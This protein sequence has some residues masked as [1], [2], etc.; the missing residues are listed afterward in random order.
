[1]PG[2]VLVREE[3]CAHSH[4]SQ[5]DQEADHEHGRTPARDVRAHLE[6]TRLLPPAHQPRSDIR[7]NRAEGDRGRERHPCAGEVRGE[8]ETDPARGQSPPVPPRHA[9]LVYHP[10]PCLLDAVQR[11][12]RFRVGWIVHHHRTLLNFPG[13]KVTLDFP[14]RKVKEWRATVRYV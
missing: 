12:S 13:W 14:G 9:D 4:E 5:Q 2:A 6:L 3:R 7:V 8:P 10:L 1:M 11:E